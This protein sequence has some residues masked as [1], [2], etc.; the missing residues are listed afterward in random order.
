[1]SQKNLLVISVDIRETRVALIEDGIIA[2]LHIERRGT[3]SQPSSVGNV[4]LGKVTR[5]LPGLQAAFIDIG[6]ERAAFLH[7]EDLIRPADFDAYLQGTR[8]QARDEDVAGPEVTG[9]EELD[10]ETEQEIEAAP[11]VAVASSESLSGSDVQAVAEAESDTSSPEDE[12]AEDEAA[13]EE[14]TNGTSPDSVADVIAQAQAEAEAEEETA[15]A[16]AADDEDDDEVD[17]LPPRDDEEPDTE[18]EAETAQAAEADSEAVTTTGSETVADA[19]DDDD[20]GDL[21]GFTVSDPGE[22]VPRAAQPRDR[23]DRGGGDRGEGGRGRG[24][25]RGRGRE[26]GRG[27][28]DDRDHDRGKREK[29]QAPSPLRISKSTP[30]TCR[31]T[32]S[33]WESTC[34]TI[35]PSGGSMSASYRAVGENRSR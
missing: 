6:Q 22:P 3:G 27:R 2:E 17:S 13:E 11:P 7:V 20:F 30:K 35:W 32:I 8:K 25:G 1:M 18:T 9:N 31:R 26:R 16:V 28:D 15:D 5:V 24:H 10:S 19:G 34:R 21:P 23:G 14:Q 4:Y 29:R 12:A 33:C